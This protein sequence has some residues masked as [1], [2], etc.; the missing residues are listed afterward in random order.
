[1]LLLVWNYYWCQLLYVE[2]HTFL[3]VICF[4]GIWLYYLFCRGIWASRAKEKS[5]SLCKE[6][7]STERRKRRK[8]RQRMVIPTA[9]RLN[10]HLTVDGSYCSGL[11]EIEKKTSPQPPTAAA[12]PW[13]KM[14]SSSSPECVD[15]PFCCTTYYCPSST[16]RRIQARWATE[17]L[18]L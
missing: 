12:G 9:D 2:I 8:R 16:W 7:S 10:M 6:L 3:P 17:T 15:A 14:C 5:P 4:G 11:Q 1:M 18:I 13:L